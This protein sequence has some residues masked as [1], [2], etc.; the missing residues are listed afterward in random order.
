MKTFDRETAEKIK[1]AAFDLD[2][3]LLNEEAGLSDYTKEIINRAMDCGMEIVIAS[4]RA[5]H[6]LPDEVVNIKGIKYAISSNGAVIYDNE[7]KERIKSCTLTPESI[8]RLFVIMENYDLPIEVF[9]DGEAHAEKDYAE[10]AMKYGVPKRG[11]EY[12]KATR[13]PEEDIWSY[14]RSNINDIDSFDI[15]CHSPDIRD[16]I[17]D[18]VRAEV[19]EI[20]L[21]SSVPHLV[22]I[23]YK[24]AG[25]ASGLK[26]LSELLGVEREEIIAFGNA[27]NDIDML[28]FAGISVAVANASEGLIRIADIIADT[29][30][31]DGVAK[32]MSELL[33]YKL[34][35]NKN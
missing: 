18:K 7:T 16:E 11:A 4:G 24:D 28:E 27:D 10:N 22:E 14:I 25:K 31:N 19:T 1:L 34:Y 17:A 20:Y 33:K 23:S 32:V 35:I 2:G 12:V 8:E 6:T 15:I 9:V 29:N 26:Y 5:Y 13:V 30:Y 3:T 21:T